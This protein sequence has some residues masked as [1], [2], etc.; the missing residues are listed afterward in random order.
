MSAPQRSSSSDVAIW[1]ESVVRIH[2]HGQLEVQALQGLDLAVDAGEMIA[3]VGPSGAGKSTLLAIL[4]GSDQP[5]AGQVRVAGRDVTALTRSERV[6]YRR[7]V[8]GAIFQQTARNVVPYLSAVQNVTMPMSCAGVRGKRA[9]TAAMDL[10]ERV[11]VADL[12][13]RLPGQMSGGQQQRVAIATAMANGPRVLLADEPTGE[14]DTATSDE[15]FAVLRDLST[16]DGVT[17][18]VVTHDPAVSERVTRTVAIRDGRTSSE[19]VRGPAGSTGRHPDGHLGRTGDIHAHSVVQEFAV[20]DKAGRIQVPREYREALG[21]T[22]RVRLTL[23]HNRVELWP[24][25]LPPRP[26]SDGQDQ[27]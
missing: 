25:A 15:I 24:D 9:H 13:Q 14:L 3:V 8:V 19:M 16:A 20:M 17:V 4:A 7:E 6:A 5:S 21:L 11:G 10:L 18:V 23:E 26:S 22:R 27:S 2:R 1:C 12:A